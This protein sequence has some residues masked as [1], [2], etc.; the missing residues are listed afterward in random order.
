MEKMWHSPPRLCG[1]Y[2]AG[3]PPAGTVAVGAGGG[4]AAWAVGDTTRGVPL[5]ESGASDA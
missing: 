5:P 4:V 2:G 1:A 3:G